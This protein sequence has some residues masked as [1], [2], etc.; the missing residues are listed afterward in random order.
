MDYRKI[1]MRL[2]LWWLLFHRGNQSSIFK[3]YTAYGPSDTLDTVT[4]GW[5]PKI[6]ISSVDEST[7]VASGI[8]HG[9]EDETSNLCGFCPEN[10]YDR[11]DPSNYYQTHA[12]GRNH[13]ELVNS[14]PVHGKYG[15][16][17]RS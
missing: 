10:H 6:N 7:V 2:I 16:G 8:G 4:P 11:L 12:E 14:T 9:M 17:D 15:F 13:R 5:A 1:A 3:R